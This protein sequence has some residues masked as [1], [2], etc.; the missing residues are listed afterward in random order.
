M[1]MAMSKTIYVKQNRGEEGGGRRREMVDFV[2][3]FR[4]FLRFY[5]FK[6]VARFVE[7]FDFAAGR[8]RLG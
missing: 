5:V 4:P 3:R 7:G 1:A 2:H 8:L 6:V